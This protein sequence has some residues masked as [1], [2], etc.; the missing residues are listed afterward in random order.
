[1]AVVAVVVVAGSGSSGNPLRLLCNFA[2]GRDSSALASA[3][4]MLQS[5]L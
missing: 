3:A 5:D 4:G 2:R 1:M